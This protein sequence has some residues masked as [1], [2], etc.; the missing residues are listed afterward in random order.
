MKLYYSPGACSLSPHIV[1]HEAG[2]D[3]QP[4]RVDLGSK[5]TVSG[6]DYHEIN[7]QGFVPALVLDDG[8]VL[9]EGPVIVQY[10]ADL[11]PELGLAPPQGT[12]A[13]YQ[14]QSTLGY[15]NSELHKSY[16]P[17]FN[18]DT[19]PAMREDRTHALL[20]RY[21]LFEDRLSERPWVE[22]EAFTVADAYLFV[23]TSWARHVGLDL[24]D[25]PALNAWHGRVAA[26]PGVRA[27]LRAEGLPA[28]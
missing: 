26:R 9:T 17:L 6:Q 2:L 16:T 27:A 3:V 18:P 15:I 23:V 28:A 20:R 25:F 10:L 21:Q 12:W 19:P 7:P 11:D 13:R 5:R 14:L 4:E 1:V 8:R 22:G 24:S